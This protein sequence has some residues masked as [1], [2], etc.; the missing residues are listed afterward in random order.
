M[1][2]RIISASEWGGGAVRREPRHQ[3]VTVTCFTPARSPDNLSAT[4][5]DSNCPGFTEY[6]ESLNSVERR[7]RHS[8]R[9]QVPAAVS[10]FY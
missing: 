4:G 9:G 3:N 6:E 5:R 8:P 1:R 10:F 2:H 7:R